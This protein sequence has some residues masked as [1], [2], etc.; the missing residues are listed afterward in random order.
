VVQS[1]RTTA[2]RLLEALARRERISRRA[3]LEAVLDDV[4]TGTCSVLEHGYLHRVER[5]HGLSAARRQVRD[6][7][8]AGTVYRDVLYAPGVIVELDGRLFHDTTTQRDRDFDRDLDT[9]A[10]GLTTVRVSWGQVFDRPCWT[11]ARIERVLIRSGWSG[12]ARP[13]GPQCS[14]RVA[15]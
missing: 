3:W 9:A 2:S 4:A 12:R 1:R 10:D 14:L 11:T 13:C 7:L 5:A 15:A 6:R 8:G